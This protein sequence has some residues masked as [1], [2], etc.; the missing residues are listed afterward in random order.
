VSDTG[1]AKWN[2]FAG[3]ADLNLKLQGYARDAKNLYTGGAIA[4]LGRKT[5]S[6][7]TRHHL[8]STC[9]LDRNYVVCFGT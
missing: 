7:S 9:L 3:L 8:S 1:D 6:M 5:C 4:A 2:R